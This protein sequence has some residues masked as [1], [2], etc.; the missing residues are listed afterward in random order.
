MLSQF[1]RNTNLVGNSDANVLADFN[2]HLG[3]RYQLMLAKLRNYRTESYEYYFQTG[4]NVIKLSTGVSQ[5]I[6]SVTSSGTTAT[7]TTSAAHGYSTND[8]VQITGVQLQSSNINASNLYGLQNNAY[9]G[10]YTITVTGTTTF[11]YTLAQSV[12]N[13]PGSPAQYF[14]YPPG[15][16]TIDG[17]FITV[18]SVNYPMRIIDTTN[19]W[20]QLNAILIQ[21][22]ALPQFYFPRRDDF[23]IWPI[24]QVTYGGTLLYHYR[25]RN[26]SVADYNTGT[27]SVTQY[28]SQLVGSGTTWTAAMVGRWFT[29][30]DTT[31]PG[32]GYWYR[33]T[34]FVDA[35]HLNIYQQWPNASASGA[36]YR[37]GETPETPEET[38]IDLVNG[39]TADFYG[40]MR[41]DPAN[42]TY[43]SNLFWTGD[44]GNPSRKEGDT[45]IAAGLIGAINRY[46]DRDDTRLVKKRP[47]LNPL[48]F[49]AWATTLSSS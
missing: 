44:P 37:I 2:L 21:A 23:G 46:G 41:K 36:T 15:E 20:E 31:V 42:Y 49:K 12:N 32:Q 18:N 5:P 25:D 28:S 13:I 34:G 47:R 27:V 35:T 10:T 39:T 26:L 9:Q 43:Y 6:A 7:V 30:T 1:Y 40:G 29:I 19:G 33:V 38:H 11:T 48:Q 22:S 8:S 24:P 3:Q 45:N 14:P 4:M 17:M 16:V